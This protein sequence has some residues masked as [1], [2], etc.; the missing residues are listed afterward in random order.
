MLQVQPAAT[1]L[2]KRLIECTGTYRGGRCGRGRVVRQEHAHGSL[3]AK[4]CTSED[5]GTSVLATTESGRYAVRSERGRQA[6]PDTACDE[7]GVM[8]I[9]KVD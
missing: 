3:R 1:G 7:G 8:A 2:I 6:A 5:T 4:V 9:R